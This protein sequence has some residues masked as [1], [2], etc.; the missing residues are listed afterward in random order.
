MSPKD[1]N[2]GMKPSKPLAR[3][4]V[5]ETYHTSGL[6]RPGESE[7]WDCHYKTGTGQEREAVFIIGFLEGRTSGESASG[8]GTCENQ[9]RFC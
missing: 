2:V 8:R 5:Q 7:C 3:W 9:N 6:C 1:W 4:V